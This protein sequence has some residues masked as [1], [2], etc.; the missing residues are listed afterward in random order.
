MNIDKNNSL[1]K[2]L[3]FLKNCGIVEN[4]KNENFG[5]LWNSVNFPND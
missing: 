1:N 5:K 3:E 4:L 2:I